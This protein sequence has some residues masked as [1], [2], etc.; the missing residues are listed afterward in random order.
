MQNTGLTRG[1][2]RS[3]NELFKLDREKYT[4]KTCSVQTDD[5]FGCARF[6]WYWT[7]QGYSPTINKVLYLNTRK[8]RNTINTYIASCTFWS[9]QWTQRFYF[10]FLSPI[11]TLLRNKVLNFKPFLLLLRAN[12]FFSYTSIACD[13]LLWVTKAFLARSKTRAIMSAFGHD[14]LKS[15]RDKPQVP[16]VGKIAKSVTRR[17]AKPR[18]VRIRWYQ[19]HVISGVIGFWRY[20][21]PLSFYRIFT[22]RMHQFPFVSCILKKERLPT[23]K[24]SQIKKKNEAMVLHSVHEN[25][26]FIFVSPTC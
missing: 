22:W 8:F 24:T 15:T 4:V 6:R 3:F 20:I 26:L 1:R 16:R 18:E 12:P 2:E 21:I 14:L 7:C 17:E 11:N 23:H 9:K 25:N 5:C 13:D 10:S 19:E